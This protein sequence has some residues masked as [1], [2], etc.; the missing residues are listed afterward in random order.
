MER[1][2]LNMK[3][4]EMGLVKNGRALPSESI[5]ALLKFSSS[6]GPKIK[7]ITKGGKR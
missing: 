4:A 6:I 1:I 5:N 2:A 7:P 3:T